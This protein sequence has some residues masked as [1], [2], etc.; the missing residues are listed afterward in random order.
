MNVA[1]VICSGS[2]AGAESVACSLT[3]A[4]EGKVDR[5]RLYLVQEVRAGADSC[6]RLVEQSRAFGIDVELFETDKRFSPRLLDELGAAL[7]RD[8]IDV[9]HN[10]SYK[11]AF[12]TALARKLR[13]RPV[14]LF[15]IHGLEQLRPKDKLFERSVN[16]LGAYLSQALI[17]VSSAIADEFRGLPLLGRRVH[18]IPNA[19]AAGAS[20]S[21]EQL[22]AG[23]EEARCALAERLG[24]L[25]TDRPWVALVGRLAPIKNHALL[26]DAIERL[27]P[28][29]DACFLI[30]GE[31]PLREMLAARIS[32]SPR[33]AERVKLTGHVDDMAAVW[34]AIDLAVLTSDSEGSPMVVLE[35]FTHGVPALC[36]RV[37]GV[38]DLVTDGEDGLLFAKGDTAGCAEHLGRL[39]GAPVLR[40][41]MGEAGYHKATVEFHPD[42][43]AERHVALYDQLLS[44][45]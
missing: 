30:V 24:G 23:R 11:A 29:T 44:R 3:K 10:H 25:P 1:N 9:I 32:A 35:A 42:R 33:L 17:G 18:T 36:S 34:S 26:L 15:T 21:L 5:A 40:A 37:G 43:W 28:S 8:G 31:G 13:R 2:F 22:R 20:S 45:S 16:A 19:L 39:L 38:P 12:F 7:G 14:S 27:E 6:A 41:K 4:L